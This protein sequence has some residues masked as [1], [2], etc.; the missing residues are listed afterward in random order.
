[1]QSFISHCGSQ[2]GICHNPTSI[3]SNVEPKHYSARSALSLL[4][5]PG[6]GIVYLL[7]RL[8]IF[9][10]DFQPCGNDS[11]AQNNQNS[12]NVVQSMSGSARLGFRHGSNGPSSNWGLEKR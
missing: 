11:R 6:K 2:S 4:P 7:R 10:W 8:N 1:M 3:V 12:F 5:E 9:A